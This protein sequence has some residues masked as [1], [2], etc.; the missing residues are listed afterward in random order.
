MR[1]LK[2]NLAQAVQ[3]SRQ[4]RGLSQEKLAAAAGIHR[5]Y[6][7]AIERGKVNVSLDVADRLAGAM[8]IRLSDL[9]RLA[10]EVQGKFW[11]ML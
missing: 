11:V 8:G 7:S 3:T 6:M 9:V 10:E 1:Q 2:V 4:A 5:T